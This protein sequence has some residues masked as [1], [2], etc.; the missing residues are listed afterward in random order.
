MLAA[1]NLLIPP[2]KQPKPHLAAHSELVQALGLEP[3]DSGLVEL[4]QTHSVEWA[5]ACHQ[6]EASAVWEV[7]HMAVWEEEWVV[8]AWGWEDSRILR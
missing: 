6:V 3:E 4:N 2:S 5:A 1:Q 7:I 8:L